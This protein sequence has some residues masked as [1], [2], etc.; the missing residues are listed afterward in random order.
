MEDGSRSNSRRRERG[1]DDDIPSY[2]NTPSHHPVFRP[3]GYQLPDR[4]INAEAED[5]ER[6]AV[7]QR[8]IR[9]R[10]QARPRRRP[11]QAQQGSL[12]E[13]EATTSSTAA[14]DALLGPRSLEA[15]DP[16]GTVSS[17]RSA[18]HGGA[19][20]FG[21]GQDQP[22]A[23]QPGDNPTPATPSARPQSSR[24]LS[25]RTSEEGGE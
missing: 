15:P 10:E 5:E 2:A 13:L 12:A 14:I 20:R 16:S 4:D 9:L 3:A 6:V 25:S 17:F 19:A 24:I 22:D 7:E 23:G 1:G 8:R 11:T 21:F 18:T